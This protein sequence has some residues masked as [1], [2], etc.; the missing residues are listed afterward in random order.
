MAEER[1]RWRGAKKPPEAV[2]R[3]KWCG[4]PP[5]GEFKGK[6]NMDETCC[7]SPPHTH[8]GISIKQPSPPWP[9]TQSEAP[10]R[11]GIKRCINNQ[12]TLGDYLVKVGG[13]ALEV[14]ELVKNARLRHKVGVVQTTNSTHSQATVL[15]E[16][17][18]TRLG[19]VTVRNLLPC[20]MGR[21]DR[22]KAEVHSGNG[23]SVWMRDLP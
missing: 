13:D 7:A 1:R 5:R 6:E 9:S 21:R 10:A 18:E 16:T 23:C 8:L 14:G 15:H 20:V 3:L 11:E 2:A 4:T 12:T 22:D 17:K 19:F